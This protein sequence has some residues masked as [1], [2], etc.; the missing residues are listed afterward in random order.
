MSY[1]KK[2]NRDLGG[3]NGFVYL[4]FLGRKTTGEN[5]IEELLTAPEYPILATP[6]DQV[7]AATSFLEKKKYLRLVEKEGRRKIRTARL[8]PLVETYQHFEFPFNEKVIRIIGKHLTFFPKYTALLLQARD[9]TIRGKE[10]S[11]L[12]EA[13]YKPFVNDIVGLAYGKILDRVLGDSNGKNPLEAVFR[14]HFDYYH[15]SSKIRASLLKAFEQQTKIVDKISLEDRREL[16]KYNWRIA[17]KPLMDAFDFGPKDRQQL[18]ALMDSF[19]SGK[20]K[21]SDLNADLEE[22][23][24]RK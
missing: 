8:E 12:F 15:L 13:F 9:A 5:V 3:Q 6:E 11:Y 4:M 7:Y 22:L 10:W 23:L 18:N 19:I 1:W 20:F 17:G 16:A 2:I 21:K 14:A 24:G